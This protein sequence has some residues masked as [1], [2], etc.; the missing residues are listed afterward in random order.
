[1]R[2]DP[3][4]ADATLADLLGIEGPRASARLTGVPTAA[5]WAA[6]DGDESTAWTTPFGHVDGA[7]LQAELVDPDAPM[8]SRQRAGNYST[9]TA[10][11][12]SQGATSADVVLGARRRGPVHVHPARRVRGRTGADR[13]HGELAERTTRDRRFGDTVLLPAAITEIGNVARTEVP[14]TFATGCRDDLVPIDGVA[15]PRARRAAASPTRWPA[16]RSTPSA[17]TTPPQ[18]LGAGAHRVTGRDRVAAPG[19]R[20]TASCSTPD[21]VEPAPTRRRADRAPR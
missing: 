12:L 21:A 9:I 6:A 20:S 16:R 4:A 1:M 18:R 19:C 14:T 3:R 7:V 11:R 8:R 15:G 13:D 10:L 5:G 17:A 2:L